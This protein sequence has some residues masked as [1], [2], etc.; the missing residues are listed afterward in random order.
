MI[1]KFAI[2]GGDRR[3]SWLAQKLLAGGFAVSCRQ[4]PG[5][6][7][8]EAAL[9]DCLRGAGAVVLPVPALRGTDAVRTERGPGIPLCSVLESLSAG[10]VLFGGCLGAVREQLSS[11]PIRA[12]DLAGLEPLATQNAAL[13]AEGALQLAMETLPIAVQGGR[14]LVIGFGRIGKALSARLRALGGL[15]T[16]SA[17]KPADCAL[18]ESFGCQ[19]DRTGQYLRG[20]ARYDCIF[21]TVPAPVL[22]RADFEAMRPD[23]PVIDL[24]S[25][26]GG[27]AEGAV[28]GGFPYLRAPG[29]PGS[30]APASAAEYLKNAIL[31]TLTAR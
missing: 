12:V 23:C 15:V 26:A 24:A 8:T 2:L 16:V 9:C 31:D 25:G 20:L 7:D 5:L 27:A 1:A 17:R 21:N 28:P 18:A 19:S 14:F 29:L 30:R 6:A 11:Y 4:V 13:T 10:T 22:L 3:Q